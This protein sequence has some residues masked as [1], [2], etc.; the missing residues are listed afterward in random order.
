MSRYL[1]GETVRRLCKKKGLSQEKVCKNDMNTA[2]ISC[3]ESRECIS[4]GDFA[5]KLLGTLIAEYYSNGEQLD[6]CEQQFYRAAV[7][8]TRS[9]KNTAHGRNT[10]LA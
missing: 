5:K 4:T 10:Y 1:L 2:T 9:K 7:A 3:I 6:T 8:I